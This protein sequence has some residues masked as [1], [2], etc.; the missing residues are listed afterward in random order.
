MDICGHSVPNTF[1]KYRDSDSYH[2]YCFLFWG[3]KAKETVYFREKKRKYNGWNSKLCL[4]QM[5]WWGYRYMRRVN[6]LSWLAWDLLIFKTEIP[7]SQN[8]LSQF[9][10]SW[11][12]SHHASMTDPSGGMCWCGGGANEGCKLNQQSHGKHHREGQQHFQPGTQRAG[13]ELNVTEPCLL[14]SSH[15]VDGLI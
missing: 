10:A 2:I 8:L 6:N 5:Q 13:L 12:I 1:L 3:K 15:P 7:E 11:D 14:S 4:R 9:W